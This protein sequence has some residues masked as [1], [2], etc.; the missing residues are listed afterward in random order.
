L[1][2]PAQQYVQ[3]LYEVSDHPDLNHLQIDSTVVTLDACAALIAVAYRGR[4][5]A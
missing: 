5:A 3:R 4:V 2:A 1:T